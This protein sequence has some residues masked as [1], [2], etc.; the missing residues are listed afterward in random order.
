MT[1]KQADGQVMDGPKNSE[2]NRQTKNR[3]ADRLKGQQT[4]EWS[5]IHT[6]KYMNRKRERT[7]R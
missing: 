6:N 1:N 2:A 7:K 4:D 3:R 5:Y